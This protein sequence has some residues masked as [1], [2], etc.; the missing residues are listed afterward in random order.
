MNRLLLVFGIVLLSVTAS[1]ESPAEKADTV[2]IPLDQIWANHIP[3]TR[4][5]HLLEPEQ[6]QK[7]I[8]RLPHDEQ[9]KVIAKA[10]LG[11]VF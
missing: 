2:T 7:N 11:P 4:D 8:E 1:A 6:R 10:L 5:I 3:G 9:L